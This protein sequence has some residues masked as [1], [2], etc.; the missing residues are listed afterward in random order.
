MSDAWK[1]IECDWQEEPLPSAKAKVT[2]ERLVTAAR[3]VGLPPESAQAGYFQTVCVHWDSGRIEVEV[4]PESFELY[5][6]P[7]D[8]AGGRFSVVEFE[9]SDPKAL[10]ALFSEIR[11]VRS[12]GSA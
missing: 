10:D 5:L 2:A 8:E 12:L 7:L 9:S 11:R 6:F 3:V 4:F 1:G